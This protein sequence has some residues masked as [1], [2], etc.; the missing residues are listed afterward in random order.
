MAIKISDKILDIPVIQGGMGVGVSLGSLAGSVAAQGGMGTISMVNIG[1]REDDFWKNPRQANERAFYK[2]V[3]KAKE[4][5]GGKGLLAANIM[6]VV[7][8]YDYLES[9]ILNSDLDAL[10][11]GAGLPLHLPKNNVKNKLLAPIVSSV[12]ALNLICRSWLKKYDALP[13]FVILE[14]KGAGGHLGF[15]REDI[16]DETLSLEGLAREMKVFLDEIKEKHGKEIPFFVGGSVMDK[17][18]LDK[19][20]AL[21]A[22]GLQI[23]TRFMVSKEADVDERVKDYVVQ[24]GSDDLEIINSPVGIIGRALKNSFIERTLRERVPAKKC[25][26]CI[27]P[28][29]PATTQYCI[30]DA[31]IATAQGDIDNG[32]IF[33][34]SRVD[35]IKEI[36][37]VKEIIDNVLGRSEG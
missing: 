8:D 26:R 22:A 12:R 19:Y 17:E 10:V 16:G 36:L 18:D 13:D 7:K 9:L 27:T 5:S 20:Q 34:G 2:E 15:S 25:I 1:Y 30:S 6:A 24:A 31:L 29:N 35:E 3:E 32:L 11:V 33:C 37:S 4:I 21:G 28:C 23:G 14:G